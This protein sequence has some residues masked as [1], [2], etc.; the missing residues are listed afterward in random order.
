MQLSALA[1]NRP[2]ATT[3]LALAVALLGCLAFTQLS[4]APLPQVDF[5]TISVQAELP[6]A[7]PET[8]AATVATPLERS[9]GQIAG[10]TEM[11]SQSSQGSTRIT[12]QF[13][14]NR[15]IDGAARDVQ[16][17][18]NAARSLLPTGLPSNPTYRK[19]NPGD[20]PIMILALTSESMTKGQMYDVASTVLA[21]KLSQVEGIGQV[22]LGGSSLPAVRVE[23]NPNALNKLGV[24]TEEVRAAIAT[25]NPYRPKGVLEN[26]ER[27]WQIEANDQARHA[28]DYAP[29]VIAYRNGAAVR[30]ADVAE[31]NDSVQDLRNMGLANGKPAVLIILSR[32][33]GANIIETVN[34]VRALLP[35]LSASIPT[36]ID[37]TVTL[38]R[39]PTI[40]ASLH[41][42]ERT[43]VIAVALVVMVVL[44]F[45]RN[46]RAALI[47]SVAVPLSLLGTFAIMYLA[48]FSLDNLSLM[49]LTVATGFVV[50]DAVVVAENIMRHIENGVP[51]RQAAIEGAREVSFTVLSMSLSLIAVFIPILMMGGV[52]GRLFREFGVTLASAV[53]VSLL[54]SLTVTPMMAGR[55]LRER[56][57]TTRGAWAMRGERFAN[58][59][60]HGYGRSLDVALRHPLITILLLLATITLNIYLYTSISK[61]FFPQQDTGRLVGNI[62]ADQSISFQAMRDKLQSFVDIVRQDPAV[63]TVVAFTGSSQKNTGIMFIGLKP[64]AERKMSADKV[65]GRLRGKVARVPGANLFLQTVQDIRMGGRPSASQYQYTLQADSIDELRTWGPRIKN[66]LAQSPQLADVNIDQFDKGVQTTLVIDRDAASRLGLSSKLIDATLNNLFGQR[67]VSTIYNPMNQYRVVM[68]AAPPFLQNPETLNSTYII[69][70]GG[71]QVPLAAFSHVEATS[72][73]L[74]VN[75]QGQLP[76]STLSF[77]LPAGVSLSEATTAISDAMRSSGAP[78]TLSGGF[79]GSAKLFQESL[80]TQPLLIL[81]AL[82]AVYIVLGM[83]YESL[84]HPLT[85][86][87]TLP[88]AG[89]GALLALLLLKMDFTIIALIGVILL[90]GIVKKNAIMMIDFALDAQRQRGMDA[91]S[92]IREA[93]LLRFRPIMMTTLAALF[94]ALPLALGTGDGAE[95]RQPL[96]V[97]VVGGLLLSQLLTLY[98]TPVVYLYLERIRE[99]GVRRRQQTLGITTQP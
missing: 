21:Q 96:G 52:I 7:S 1:I 8:M 87:S 4:V 73:P 38:D 14:I 19:V 90:I 88:S 28:A 75:H 16:A 45:L 64:V 15:N 57:V 43:L 89:V 84:I 36:A 86:L 13:D 34:R 60:R 18:L 85:I 53:A 94:G 31:V 98:T 12:L 58:G 79:Q 17:A 99:W 92:A 81:A 33:P 35:A 66:L 23:L 67:Q 30:L 11:T 42:V 9:L 49:A 47:P 22:S 69:A 51:P 61:N 10:V 39:T 91:R 48:G 82:L 65:I 76:S 44:L 2:V 56:A 77:N 83:L 24:S 5:P 59:L 37:L 80:A 63:D 71:M 26:D 72:A 3:L 68:E 32:Q 40:R 50:D 93:S 6:G 41:D 25:T 55:L 46:A 54:V 78:G 29:L 20:A 95:L 27:H 97:A 70:P 74:V 62:Q